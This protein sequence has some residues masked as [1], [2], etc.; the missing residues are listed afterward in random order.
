M[1]GLGNLSD[2]GPARAGTAI[3]AVF[4]NCLRFPR[5][6][7]PTR[8]WRYRSGCPPRRAGT[9]RLN[10]VPAGKGKPPGPLPEVVIL[11]IYPGGKRRCLRI[12]FGHYPVHGRL[13]RLL[14]VFESTSV[15]VTFYERVV[16]QIGGR[17]VHLP[18]AV[19]R[20]RELPVVRLQS[21]SLHQLTN[22]R[23]YEV[24]LRVRERHR[25]VEFET[26]PVHH[27][28]E[29]RA[30]VRQSMSARMTRQ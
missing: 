12:C 27:D 17:A 20:R 11:G 16:V 15:S 8:Q 4:E 6:S 1:Q 19:I 21:F 28:R 23:Q 26:E 13:D 25:Q 18:P 10:S 7:A 14:P 29:I 3:V 5:V 24:A 2:L 9:H 22:G 30:P